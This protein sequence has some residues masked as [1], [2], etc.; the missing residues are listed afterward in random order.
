MEWVFKTFLVCQ[1]RKE[2][3]KLDI[4]DEWKKKRYKREQSLLL[5]GLDLN[6]KFY[7]TINSHCISLKDFTWYY[8]LAANMIY[9]QM[10]EKQSEKIK[11]NKYK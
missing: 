2:A 9:P 8:Q 6:P 4:K 5:W 11:W 10:I 1:G 7:G 3:E